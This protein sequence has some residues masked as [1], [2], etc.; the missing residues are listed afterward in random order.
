MKKI[1]KI[2][3]CQS[4][5][6]TGIYVGVGERDGAAVVC[7]V[8]K[9][10]GKYTYIFEYEEFTGLK[11]REDVTRVYKKTYGFVIA[12]RQLIF[13]DI[14]EIDMASEGVTYHDFKNG[15]MPGHIK[16]LVCPMFADQA[17]CHKIE[18]FVSGCEQLDPNILF[19]KL[20]SQCTNQI[21]KLDC[22]K[23]F[24]QTKK[25]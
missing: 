14:G 7:N 8:C 4:C 6:G 19:G 22:W 5:E 17:A 18:G 15:H 20:L 11:S 16:Q 12:P 25:R 3:Q 13:K 2:I 23:R 21:N 24:K 9:G 10:T 1:E